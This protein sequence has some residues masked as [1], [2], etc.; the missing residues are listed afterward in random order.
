MI[1]MA[2]FAIVWGCIGVI[3]NKPLTKRHLNRYPEHTR[4]KWLVIGRIAYVVVGCWMIF[5]GLR[6]LG[7]L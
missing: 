7:Y 2:Y 1:F 4:A 6:H 5:I 3:F